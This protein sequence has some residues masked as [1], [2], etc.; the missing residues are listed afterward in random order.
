MDV[1]SN[2][3][4]FLIN[5]LPVVDLPSYLTDLIVDLTTY[6]YWAN[7]YLPLDTIAGCVLAVVAVVDAIHVFKFLLSIVDF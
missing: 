6:A 5:L 7:Y 3:F 1:V 2:F 4:K